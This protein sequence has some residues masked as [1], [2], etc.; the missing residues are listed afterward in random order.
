MPEPSQ[1][2][3]G[4]DHQGCRGD[5]QAE[6]DLPAACGTVLPG[7]L[8]YIEPGQADQ[9]AQEVEGGAV[10]AH[11]AAVGDGVDNHRRKGTETDQVTE[12]VNLDAKAF[13]L[14]GADLGGGDLA[15]KHVAH[16]GEHETHQGSVEVPLYGTGDAS[17]RNEHPE[18]SQDYRVVVDAEHGVYLLKNFLQ[19]LAK[20][21]RTNA[22][23]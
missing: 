17:E 15:V 12:G 6:I 5:G 22:V 21:H 10:E 9:G 8:V 3:E 13:L 18:V 2:Q 14:G 23:P 20:R 19:G 11:V 1:P 4:G 16:P 7:L